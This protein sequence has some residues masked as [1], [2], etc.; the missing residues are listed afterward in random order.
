MISTGRWGRLLAGRVFGTGAAE[1]ERTVE[2]ASERWLV[3][4]L[5]WLEL[6]AEA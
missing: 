2:V 1:K 6:A 4:S 5:G 3:L